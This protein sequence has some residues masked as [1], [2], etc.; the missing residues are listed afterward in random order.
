MRNI[1]LVMSS[2]VVS[3]LV[4]GGCPKW[5]APE[6]H[7]L[8]LDPDQSVRPLTLQHDLL[9]QVVEDVRFAH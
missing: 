4:L 6:N 9:R 8:F 1:C 2:V 5:P 3:L 7:D